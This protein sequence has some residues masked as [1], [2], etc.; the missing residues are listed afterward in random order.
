M[1]AYSVMMQIGVFVSIIGISGCG[2]ES[3]SGDSTTVV[4]VSEDTTLDRDMHNTQFRIRGNGTD[5]NLNG[6]TLSFDTD[7]N[8]VILEAGYIGHGVSN[9]RLVGKPFGNGIYIASSVRE[10]DVQKLNQSIGYESVIYS[11]S[12][13]N[14]FVRDMVIDGFNNGIYVAPYIVGADITNNRITKVDNVGLYFDTASMGSTVTGNIFSDNGW[15]EADSAFAR[16]RGHLSVDASYDNTI[17][18]NTFTDTKYKWALFGGGSNY[19]APMVE[20]YRNCGEP[21]RD[22]LTHPVL[23]RLHGA[24]SNVISGN[25][26][27]GDG[28]AMWFAYREHNNICTPVIYPDKAD[29]NVAAGNVFGSGVEHV[30]DDG[31]N[32]TY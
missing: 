2:G 14:P 17:T 32:N 27:N 20:L 4:V 19:P 13:H 21:N 6:H 7:G 29:N 5:F 3:H 11:R 22:W 1:Q 10:S 24:D 8:H 16:K 23:P 30:R 9:G 15:R 25:T 18:G 31:N 28:L 26:F 12:S